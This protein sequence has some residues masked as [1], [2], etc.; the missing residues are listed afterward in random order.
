V[1]LICDRCEADCTDYKYAVQTDPWEKPTGDVYCENCHELLWT[2]QQ[3]KLM[4]ET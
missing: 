1:R 2:R 4:E 3:E